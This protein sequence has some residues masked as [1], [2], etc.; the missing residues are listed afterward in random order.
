MAEI[1]WCAERLAPYHKLNTCLFYNNGAFSFY[2][3]Y[4]KRFG[5]ISHLPYDIPS[6]ACFIFKKNAMHDSRL[7]QFFGKKA[8]L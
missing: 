1:V 2:V 3:E 4:S 5:R 7:G 6:K 8:I